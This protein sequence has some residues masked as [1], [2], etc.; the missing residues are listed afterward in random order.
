MSLQTWTG[1]PAEGRVN[2]EYVCPLSFGSCI[3]TTPVPRRRAYRRACFT[4]CRRKVSDSHKLLI[5]G[6]R[7]ECW[8]RADGRANPYLL[9]PIWRCTGAI[10]ILR[11]RHNDRSLVLHGL[12]LYPC[13]RAFLQRSWAFVH[14]ISPGVLCRQYRRVLVRV[15]RLLAAYFWT[16]A[17]A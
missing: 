1:R 5:C 6:Y 15:K 8:I 16:I 12:L 7:H 10:P 2:T 4:N 3:I 13:A 11:L 9:L 17:S 14:R